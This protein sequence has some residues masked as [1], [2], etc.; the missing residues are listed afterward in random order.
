MNTSKERRKKLEIFENKRKSSLSYSKIF[1]SKVS[2]PL[3]VV[4][5]AL[6]G[7]EVDGFEAMIEINSLLEDG[8]LSLL[9]GTLVLVVGNPFAYLKGKR[10]LKHDMNRSFLKEQETQCLEVSRTKEISHFL[11]TLSEKFTTEKKFFVDLHST[12]KGAELLVYRSDNEVL[13]TF[14]EKIS[15]LPL[16]FTYKEG[17][18]EGVLIDEAHKQGF[19]SFVVE[20]GLS[21]KNSSVALAKAHLSQLLFLT[22]MITQKDLLLLYSPSKNNKEKSQQRR[23]ETISP[24]CVRK[25]FRFADENVQTETFYPKGTVYAFD[26][27]VGELRAEE[28]LFIFMPSKNVRPDD[29]D[30]G[31]LCRR[32]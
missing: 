15:T 30:A 20:C 17:H 4:V 28:D 2:G 10:Y 32:L 22:G 23:Y 24:I 31:F 3:V 16:H 7:D 1:S 29:K 13:R 5:G 12:S 9:C 21:G 18:I 11:Q 26:N 27:V 14:L 8:T 19:Q 6:H 25:G